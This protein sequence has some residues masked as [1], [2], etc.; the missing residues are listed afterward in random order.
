MLLDMCTP[1]H[2]KMLWLWIYETRIIY[3]LEKPYVILVTFNDSWWQVN[4]VISA[5]VGLFSP[6][7]LWIMN[8]LLSICSAVVVN[9]SGP[10]CV[11]IDNI[12][13]LGVDK[14]GKVRILNDWKY[15]LCQTHDPICAMIVTNCFCSC[16]IFSPEIYLHFSTNLDFT[17]KEFPYY[18]R[19]GL[20]G[21][22]L[23]ELYSHYELQW[24]TNIHLISLP[25]RW[26][27]KHKINFKNQIWKSSSFL[28]SLHRIS[29]PWINHVLTTVYAEPHVYIEITSVA[30]L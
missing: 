25:F 26:L 17:V 9:R 15:F 29:P 4:I 16:F 24:K 1:F 18:S 2:C 21:F 22:Q 27:Q 23:S 11:S 30:F 10:C 28:E 13:V 20:Y 7:V 8:V 3:F 19:N 5:Y 12:R 14:H 6:R